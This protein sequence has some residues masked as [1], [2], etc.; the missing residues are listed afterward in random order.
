M[1]YTAFE[2]IA[3]SLAALLQEIPREWDGKQAILEMKESGFRHWKQ[4]E[5]MGFYFEFLCEKFLSAKDGDPLILM[6]VKDEK[7]SYNNVQFDGFFEI[8]WDY[9]AHATNTSNHT[10]VINDREAIER[11]VNDYGA[12]GVIMAIGDVEYNDENET[13]K[14][15]HR[16]LKGG[17]SEY[18]KQRKKRGAWSR[19]RKTR[20]SLKQIVFIRVN[21]ETLDHAGSFQRGFRNSD[22]NPRREKVLLSLEDLSDTDYYSVEF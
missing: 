22:G 20:F 8:P 18:E 9:K 17:E 5:W 19:P 13:F 21:K 11:A 6:M 12:I 2:K 3:K 4:M 16:A 1:E 15:W 10:V 7:G 14:K